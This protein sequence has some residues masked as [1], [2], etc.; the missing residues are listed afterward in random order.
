MSNF[1]RVFAALLICSIAVVAGLRAEPAFAAD[2][3]I[4]GGMKTVRPQHQTGAASMKLEDFA[5]RAP[6][7]N[8]T[9]WTDGCRSC[10]KNA[11][12]VSCSN[13]GIACV[14]SEPRCTRP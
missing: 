3:P 7:Q 6:N 13:V 11:D 1:G 2:L 5:S 12:G 10:G 8:C 9:A 4:G 14:A